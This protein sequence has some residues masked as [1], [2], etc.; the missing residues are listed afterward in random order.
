MTHEMSPGT[1]A[2]GK[3]HASLRAAAEREASASRAAASSSN[4]LSVRLARSVMSSGVV[5]DAG[6]RINSRSISS[7][8][9]FISYLWFVGG[10]DVDVAVCRL[11]HQLVGG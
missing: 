4:L 5:G 1:F 3:P 2:S 6:R 8:F 11:D 10:V 9:N 7:R